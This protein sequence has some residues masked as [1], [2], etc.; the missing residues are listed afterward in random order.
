MSLSDVKG[1]V[2]AVAVAIT[3]A[4]CAIQTVPVRG[5]PEQ[6]PLAQRHDARVLVHYAPAVREAGYSDA[7]MNVAIGA[8]SV[9]RL[10]QAFQALFSSVTQVSV[11]PPW[12]DGLLAVDGVIEVDE[13]GIEVVRGVRDL[14]S[15]SALHS[16]GTPHK[17]IVHYHACLYRPNGAKLECW[18]AD[19]LRERQ[20]GFFETEVES[21]AALAGQA[22]SDAVA[23]LVRMIEED[24]AVQRW[25][26]QP[27]GVASAVSTASRIAILAWPLQSVGLDDE[28][29]LVGC[30]QRS[31]A[32]ELP[33]VEFVG[34][35]RVR[36]ALYPLLQ[37]STEPRTEVELTRLLARA[38]VQGRLRELGLGYLI[39]FAGGTRDGETRGLADCGYMGCSGFV[40]QSE[41]SRLD[42]VMWQLGGEP[43]AQSMSAAAQGT[44]FT[45]FVV[46]PIPIP[47]RTL[48]EACAE[49]GRKIA[50]TIKAPAM[51]S[52]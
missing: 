46:F 5:A 28:G 17:V 36:A 47:A 2:R 45:P 19:A 20:L 31:I 1:L 16:L 21:V 24:S 25:V 9:E 51:P 10:D 42:A 22:M 35:S 44:N 30:I 39:A 8:A 33:G 52:P 14:P 27:T 11:W 40:W 37:L 23:K 26:A 6:V 49:L 38:E 41:E 34:P 43:R 32:S 50:E 18:K 12:S 3:V 7:L 48:D 29:E 4:G 15:S 13:A